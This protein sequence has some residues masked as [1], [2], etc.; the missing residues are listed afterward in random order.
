MGKTLVHT[1]LRSAGDGSSFS[2]IRIASA[3]TRGHTA[4]VRDPLKLAK[5]VPI[6]VDDE[7]PAFYQQEFIETVCLLFQY[8][9]MSEGDPLRWPLLSLFLARDYIGGFQVE[10]PSTRR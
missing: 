3:K 1:A 4:N 6:R 10:T 7:A 9:G 5:P 8:Y 2:S